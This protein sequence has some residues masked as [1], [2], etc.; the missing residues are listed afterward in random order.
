MAA[1]AVA[2]ETRIMAHYLMNAL[3]QVATQPVALLFAFLLGTVSAAAS[4]CCTLPTL[5]ILL[6]YSG[7]RE[8]GDRRAAV[9]FTITFT[10]GIILSLVIIGAIA[11][12]VGNVAQGMLGKYWKI[13]AGVVAV[14]LGLV[15]L[16]LL[17]LKVPSVIRPTTSRKTSVLG[18]TVMGLLLGGGVAASSLPCNPGIF[19]VLGAAILQGQTVWAMLLLASFAVGFSLPLGAILLGVSLGK[20]TLL[21]GKMNVVV[22]V[23]SGAVLLGAGFYLLIS[24]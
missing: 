5:G 10:I 9:R 24:L 14:I 15:T 18:A 2:G 19:I 8:E 22:R 16:K 3:Q 7:A 1:V 6:G 23:I 21:V 11:G 13:F 12:F 20:T 4:A 17:P